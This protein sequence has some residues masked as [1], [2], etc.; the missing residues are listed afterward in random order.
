MSIPIHRI[1][2][3]VPMAVMASIYFVCTWLGWIPEALGPFMT[4]FLFSL[5]FPTL[6]LERYYMGKGKL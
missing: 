1:F 6:I 5:L 2:A 3:A 4:I